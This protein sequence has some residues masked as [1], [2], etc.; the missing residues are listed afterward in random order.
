MILSRKAV[1]IYQFYDVKLDF[2]TNNIVT[3]EKKAVSTIGPTVDKILLYTC[4]IQ[5]LHV[6]VQLK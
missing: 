2:I 3:I 4:K 1:R 5:S 6:H